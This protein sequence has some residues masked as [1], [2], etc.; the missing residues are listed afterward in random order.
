MKKKIHGNHMKNELTYQIYGSQD[1]KDYDVMAFLEEIP[2][3]V[4][5]AHA[6]IETLENEITQDFMAFGFP[7]KEVHVNLAV[8]K[9][10]LVDKVFK[11]T[12]DEVNNSM[13]FTYDLHKKF[14]RFPQHI[15]SEV[16]RNI[17]TKYLRTAR[18][19]L[20]FFSRTEKRKE[21]KQALRSDLKAKLDVLKDIDF[22]MKYD[23]SGKNE[24]EEDIYKVIAFQIAQTVGLFDEKQIYTKSEAI[25]YMTEFYNFIERKQLSQKDLNNLEFKKKEFIKIGIDCMHTF[26]SLV[27]H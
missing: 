6:L 21:I 14:Q 15:K 19:L 10:G 16:S 3:D 7:S 18:V 8:V 17:E 24:T 27:E 4:K 11:G 9:R 2:S 12:E 26:D 25:S 22:S 20:S 13:Y 23:F 1:S 5:I